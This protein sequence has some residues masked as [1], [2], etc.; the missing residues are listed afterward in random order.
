ML[1]CCQPGQTKVKGIQLL[2]KFV[3]VSQI[4]K[5]SY[6]RITLS[7]NAFTNIDYGLK[8][9]KINLIIDGEESVRDLSF[10]EGREDTHLIA[11]FK[12]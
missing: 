7:Q 9:R 11:A 3:F 6:P 10:L 4:S 1:T 5:L 8:S 2:N 12:G